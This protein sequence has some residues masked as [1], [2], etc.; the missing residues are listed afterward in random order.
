MFS[1]TG[2]LWRCQLTDFDTS[3]RSMS[4]E[5]AR[6]HSEKARLQVM[7]DQ[8]EKE[9]L[10]LRDPDK[11]MVHNLRILQDEV[12]LLRTQT[13]RLNEE[14]VRSTF[15]FIFLRFCLE[16]VEQVHSFCFNEEKVRSTFCFIFLRFC[17]EHVEQVTHRRQGAL[18]FLFYFLKVLP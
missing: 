13:R 8:K 7:L 4:A 17:L 3:N 14:K 1:L 16:H 12:T 15:C 2:R 18:N 5:L 11:E 9:I 10:H 6:L